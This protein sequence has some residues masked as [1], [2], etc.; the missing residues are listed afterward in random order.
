MSCLLALCSLDVHSEHVIVHIVALGATDLEV[1]DLSESDWVGVSVDVY[2]ARDEADDAVVNSWLILGGGDGMLEGWELSELLDDGL[3]LGNTTWSAN[4][5]KINRL[6][7]NDY[8][9]WDH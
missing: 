5:L 6:I 1:E 2:R 3:G 4:L 7:K 8:F 9:G